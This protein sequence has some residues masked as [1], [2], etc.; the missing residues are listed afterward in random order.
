[1]HFLLINN[2]TQQVCMHISMKND[3]YN[4]YRFFFIKSKDMFRSNLVWNILQNFLDDRLI[5]QGKSMCF[6]FIFHIQAILV[7]MVVAP[8]RY[9][10]HIVGCGAWRR[11]LIRLV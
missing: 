4:N 5:I 2:I 7:R 3:E 10:G 1:M 9:Y 11:A 6:M 8:T